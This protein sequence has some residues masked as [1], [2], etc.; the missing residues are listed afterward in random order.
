MI[1]SRHAA[2]ASSLVTQNS[3]EE[4]GPPSQIEL[5]SS[6]GA[7]EWLGCY[8]GL[9]QLLPDGDSRGP[10]Y[11]QRHDGDN[12]QIYLYRAGDFWLIG[13][14]VGKKIGALSAKVENNQ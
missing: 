3:S 12:Q 14:E 6:G 10:V 11:R 13:P 1:L 9:F 2:T 5:R 4:K 8:L 7:G